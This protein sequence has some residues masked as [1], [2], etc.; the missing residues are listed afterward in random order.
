MSQNN[1]LIEFSLEGQESLLNGLVNYLKETYL[2]CGE[3]VFNISYG[4]NDDGDDEERNTFIEF[5]GQDVTCGLE[6]CLSKI[7]EASS[8]LPI[9]S[10]YWDQVG[11]YG[12]ACLVENKLTHFS[13]MDSLKKFLARDTS[14]AP[15]IKFIDTYADQDLV[16]LT[17]LRFK[18]KKIK[19]LNEFSEIVQ[20]YISSKSNDDFIQLL[21]YYLGFVSQALSNSAT[22][23]T[24]G[25]TSAMEVI[26]PLVN[27]K[28]A[29]NVQAKIFSMKNNIKSEWLIYDVPDADYMCFEE[30]RS[31]VTVW[32]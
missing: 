6:K 5:D 24:Y 11:S 32:F 25:W 20:Q 14:N 18:K 29:K 10:I 30:E 17:K 8:I 19:A 7:S 2:D 23:C 27:I 13:D 3:E 28:G 26:I 15:E 12:Y 4:K 31:L 21:S 22:Q 16:M 1:C 9:A